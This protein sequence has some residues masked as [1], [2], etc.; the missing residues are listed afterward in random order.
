MSDGSEMLRSCMM[1]VGGLPMQKGGLPMHYLETTMPVPADAPVVILVHGLA[2]SGQYMVP[3]ARALGPFCQV[4]VPDFPGFGDSGKPSRVL[5]VPKLADSLAAWMEAMELNES[6]LLGNSFGCQIIGEFAVRHPQK[7]QRAILQGPTTDPDERSWIMQFIRWRQNAP[8]NPP[9]M[10]DVADIDYEK[11][12]LVRAITTFEFGLRHELERIL[13]FIAV[14]TLV[15]RGESDPICT[16]GWAERV[17]R[18]LPDGALVLIA[19][20]AHTLVFTDPEKL[21]SAVRSFVIQAKP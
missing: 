9:R 6:V 19:D 1:P 18:L 4:Y 17:E 8:F 13:P 2:L 16:Q 15:V 12:G 20:A 3:T 7:V 21:A 10:S 14:P 11:C 5:D